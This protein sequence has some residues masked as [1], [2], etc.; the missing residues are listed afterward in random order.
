[1]IDAPRETRREAIH[2]RDLKHNT[3]NYF[4]FY[5]LFFLFAVWQKQP[6]L[7]WQHLRHPTKLKTLY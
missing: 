1:M 4:M 2:M 3:F 5:T 7:I 6:L